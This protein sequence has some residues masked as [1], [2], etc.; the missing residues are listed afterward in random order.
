MSQYYDFSAWVRVYDE[1]QLLAAALA[2]PDAIEANM[3]ESDFLD[4]DGNVDVS[5]CLKMVMD[6]GSLPGCSIDDCTVERK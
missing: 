3:V 1:R 2:H 6:P 5:E 4:A